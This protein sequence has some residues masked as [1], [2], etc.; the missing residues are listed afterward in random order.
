MADRVHGS[1]GG[2]EEMTKQERSAGRGHKSP[3]VKRP[4]ELSSDMRISL[5]W[6]G[7][8]SQ[9]QINKQQSVLLMYFL[10]ITF[11]DLINCIK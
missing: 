6:I 5:L 9:R 10:N 2:H 4:A 7:F 3:P 1:S 8:I 11:S